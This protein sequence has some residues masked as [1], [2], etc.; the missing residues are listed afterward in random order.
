M[1]LWQ[2]NGI[3]TDLLTVDNAKTAEQSKVNGNYS[4]ELF[5]CGAGYGG[6]HRYKCSRSDPQG[7]D[8]NKTFIIQIIPYIN[9]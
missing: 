6:Q 7:E 4:G 9:F 2:K 8:K 5:I 1:D 3:M